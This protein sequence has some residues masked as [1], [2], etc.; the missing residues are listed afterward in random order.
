VYWPD[1]GYTK[2]DLI[3]YYAQVADFMVPYLKDR[4]LSLLRHPNGI[5]GQSFFQKDMS[6]QPPP[7]WV[8]TVRLRSESKDKEKQ[9]IICQ[10]QATLLYLANLGCIEINPWNARIGSLEQADYIL[11]DLDPEDIAFD[12][13]VGVA[14]EARRVLDEIG[15]AG[16]CKISGKRGLHVYVPLRAGYSHEQAKQFAQLLAHLV[17]ARLPGVTSLVRDPAKRQRLVY[18]DFLQ[19][20]KGKTL[21]AAYSVRPVPGARVSTPLAWKEVRRGLDPAQFTI[22]TMARR[23]DKVGDL[24]AGV[25]GPGI[26]LMA[27]LE[28]VNRLLSKSANAGR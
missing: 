15:A 11:L 21:A 13:V 12:E 10:D 16:Y 18:V 1:E 7:D 25:L 22:K 5:H 2:G 17:H 26:D 9:S 8:H 3:R 6:A 20:G 28:R 14:K 27:C 4:P 24:W 23:L 19:N